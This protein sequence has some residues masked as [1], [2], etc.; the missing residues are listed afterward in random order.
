MESQIPTNEIDEELYTYFKRLMHN[1][2]DNLINDARFYISP[3][4][5]ETFR[6]DAIKKI[7][8]GMQKDKIKTGLE[9]FEKSQA[10]QKLSTGIQMLDF[11][12]DGGLSRNK[13]YEI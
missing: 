12:L 11:K 8:K 1:D 3:D 6:I 5:E 2:L 4:A 9:L 10:I 13:I 7:I